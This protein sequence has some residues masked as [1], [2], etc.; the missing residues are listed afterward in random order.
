[1]KNVSDVTTQKGTFGD[2]NLFLRGFQT[3]T[4]FRNGFRMDGPG[5]PQ[6]QQ[7]ANVERIEVLK[8]PAAILYGRV[9]PGGM[10]NIITKQPLATP[11]YS[12]TRQF[13]SYDLYRTSLDATGPLTNDETLLY[14][15]N[16]SYQNSGSFRDPVSN[17]DIF[18]AP[19]LK[20]NISPRTQATLEMEYLHKL[21]NI[22]NQFLPLDGNR[23]INLPPSRNLG[24][25]NQLKTENIFVGFNWSHQFNDD[26]LIKHQMFFK[27]QN[28]NSDGY[29]FPSNIRL[30][31]REVDR[32]LVRGNFTANTVANILDLT[33]HFKTWGLEHTL[34]LGGD[35][36][37][38]DF[39]QDLVFG[40]ISP[41]NI[42]HPVHGAPGVFDPSSRSQ[43]S[44]TA[45]NYG[46]YL[47]DQITLPYHVHVM[48][49]LRYQNM[50]MTN[51]SA[52]ADGVFT[53]GDPQTDHAVTPRVGLLWQPQNWL[54]L[55]SNYAENFGANN[56][57]GFGNK[58]LP[59][60]SAQQWEVGAKSEF[61]DGR[62]SA[63]LAYY[64]LTKQN[65][66]TTD[67][68]HL[69]ECGGGPC[70]LAVGEARS[71]GPELEIPL[72]PPAM[73]W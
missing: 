57:C 11:Y 9:E 43:F 1:L 49:G 13:G 61:F 69:F 37:Y 59:P 14:R 29:T 32:F 56:G 16:M 39:P 4:L 20:W 10:V 12:L 65:V 26:W 34:L 55:Y 21:S 18:L 64:N 60:Q 3:G 53:P 28:D 63:T 30:G 47:Q 50:H 72:N 73:S 45:N 35:Y 68:A 23:V 17:E 36:Y 25:R 70:L 52:G 19:I 44:Q 54:S 27:R 24:E 40:S 15:F 31:D 8:G 7:F 42:D 48:G 58:P 66:A 5:S 6:G 2:D 51:K 33:G 67:P 71:K 22:D 38:F 46:L 41:I 62:L